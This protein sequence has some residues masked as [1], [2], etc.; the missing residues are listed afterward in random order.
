MKH[1]HFKL[2][3]S[4][5]TLLIVSLGIDAQTVMQ[6]GE[7]ELFIYTRVIDNQKFFVIQQGNHISTYPLQSGECGDISDDGRYLAV[8]STQAST[9]EIIYMPS[10]KV[11]FSTEWRSEWNPCE[12]YW[13][14]NNWLMMGTSDIQDPIFRFENFALYP[15]PYETIFLD[16]PSLPNFFPNT[17]ESFIQ[18]SPANPDIYLYERCLRGVI[19]NEIDCLSTEMVVYD[20]ANNQELEILEN[21]NPYT[22][23]GYEVDTTKPYNRNYISA[24][25]VSWSSDGRY[26]AYFYSP[27]ADETEGRII[28]YDIEQD[29]Y[30]PDPANLSFEPNIWVPLQWSSNNILV[31]WMKAPPGATAAISDFLNYFVFVHADTGLVANS[32]IFDVRQAIFAPD[33]HVLAIVGKEPAESQETFNFDGVIPA[34]LIFINTSTTG[35]STIIDTNVTEIITWRSIC[36]FTP[37]DTASL[38]STMQSEPYS[39]ICLAENG[40]YDLTAPLPDVAGDI[41]IIGNGATINMTAQNR[42]FNVVYNQQWSR[43]G[44]LTLKDVTISG[45]NATEGGAIANTGELNLEDVIF[46]NGE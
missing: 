2:F 14:S 3:A 26:I 6:I 28:I 36:D 19:F 12:L 1:N 4:L 8:S 39:V 7:D 45:G 15:V 37:L 38:I 34:D 5:I 17:L 11:V 13:I 21:A 35:E 16:Y 25:L 18:Q 29:I 33:G 42:V 20:L 44:T 41:T 22:F 23:R 40:Q 30:L 46:E 27:N 10:Q 9:L 24:S 32:Y 43:N 31:Y